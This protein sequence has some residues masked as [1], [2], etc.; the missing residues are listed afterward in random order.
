MLSQV[1]AIRKGIL[2]V[3]GRKSTTYYACINFVPNTVL[4]FGLFYNIFYFYIYNL[5]RIKF[6]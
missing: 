1:F 4:N 2:A 3:S 6:Y 5:L